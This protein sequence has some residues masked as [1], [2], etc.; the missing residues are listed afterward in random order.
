MPGLEEEP[1]EWL[2][3][4][5]EPFAAGRR[6][7]REGVHLTLKTAEGEISVHLGPDAWVDQQELK[8]A[9]GDSITVKGSKVTFEGGPAIIAQSV[10]R[11]GETL[12][13]RNSDGMPV[14][15][16]PPNN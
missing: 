4:P 8:L 15:P 2:S 6:L 13:L 3:S 11:G 16:R 5:L 10:T 1:D 14:W 7:R 9:K 12:V